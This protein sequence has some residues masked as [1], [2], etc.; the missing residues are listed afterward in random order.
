MPVPTHRRR[1]NTEEKAKVLATAW[2]T[3]L[4]PFLATLTF[5]HQDDL[6]KRITLLGGMDGLKKWVIIWFTPPIPKH[7]F[8]PKTF[9]QIILAATWLVQH[10]RMSLNQQRRPLSSLLYLSSF[11]VPTTSSGGRKWRG[12]PTTTTFQPWRTT[13]ATLPRSGPTEVFFIVLK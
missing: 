1:I 7:M 12:S 6:K 10:S 11:Y 8:S 4:I 3:E 5:F 2:G 13:C 9:L